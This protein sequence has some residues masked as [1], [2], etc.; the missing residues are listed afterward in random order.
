MNISNRYPKDKFNELAKPIISNDVVLN[1]ILLDLL[2]TRFW[3][4]LTNAHL[5]A[6]DTL[7]YIIGSQYGSVKTL[8]EYWMTWLK[9]KGYL[10]DVIP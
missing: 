6:S 10:L 2:W 3:H 7:H 1:N 9:E 4:D 8:H 5:C